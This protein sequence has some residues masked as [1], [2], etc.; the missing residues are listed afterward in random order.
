MTSNPDDLQ[1]VAPA[2]VIPAGWGAKALG[3]LSTIPVGM[4]GQLG[5]HGGPHKWA[6]EAGRPL[7]R[8]RLENVGQG[9]GAQVY[10]H[11]FYVA[12]NPKVA[13][14]YK[15]DLSRGLP[16][17]EY[18]GKPL[19]ELTGLGQGLEFEEQAA[20]KLALWV[21]GGGSVDQWKRTEI[22][23]L[24]AANARHAGDD[25]LNRLIVAANND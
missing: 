9:E 12:E 20:R 5:W 13:G 15:A 7:G 3:L 22:E 11:G 16:T 14:E 17:V 18:K 23:R 19:P 24:L 21:R 25:E 8:P 6:P 1:V 10:G 2:D 4:I